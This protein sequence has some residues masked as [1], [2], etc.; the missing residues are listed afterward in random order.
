MSRIFEESRMMHSESDLEAVVAG[1][2][3]M[4]VTFVT[5]QIKQKKEIDFVEVKKNGV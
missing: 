3:P 4:R 2:N 1:E 5:K